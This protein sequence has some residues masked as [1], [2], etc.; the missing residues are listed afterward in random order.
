MKKQIGAY[1]PT[2][3]THYDSWD[4][5]VEAEADGYCVIIVG[6]EETRPTTTLFANLIGVRPTKEEANKLRSNTRRRRDN[7]GLTGYKYRFFV[8]PNWRNK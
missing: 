6:Y 2:T 3:D 4:A 8:R 7:E 1:S 5:L